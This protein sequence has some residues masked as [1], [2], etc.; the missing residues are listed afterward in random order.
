MQRSVVSTKPR[1]L[2]SGARVRV[3]GR[4]GA[5]GSVAHV[6]IA[7][8]RSIWGVDDLALRAC[9]CR[10]PGADEAEAQSDPRAAAPAATAVVPAAEAAAEAALAE[11]R[12]GSGGKRNR[13]KSGRCSE[14]ES[15]LADHGGLSSVGWSIGSDACLSSSCLLVISTRELVQCANGRPSFCCNIDGASFYDSL[16][17]QVLRPRHHAASLVGVAEEGRMR[18]HTLISLLTA[19]AAVAAAGWSFAAPNPGFVFADKRAT[20]VPVDA[21][22]VIAVDVSNSMDPEEQALQRE[23]YILGLTSREFLQALRNGNYGRIA[24][25][26]F[27]WAGMYDQKIVL[28][29][30]VIDGRESAEA[31][32]NEIKRTPYRR[33]PRTSIFGALQF[34]KPLFDSSGYG[35]FRRIF[36]FSGDR[37]NNMGPP[38]TIMRDDVVG[39]GITINGL[40]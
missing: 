30:R 38:V 23:G 21:E 5:A 9:G 32:T 17:A 18:A 36:A 39:A 15:H 25:T 10:D 37:N 27:E 7:D 14:N 2:A 3:Y 40:P 34:A 13:T 19:G 31:I 8:H 1:M 29:W 28:P 6:H 11:G 35:G 16:L 22:L 24:V 26:Y 33:A 20:A 12:G 4:C